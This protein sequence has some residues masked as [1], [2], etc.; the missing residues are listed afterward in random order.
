MGGGNKSDYIVLSMIMRKETDS[1]IYIYISKLNR[2]F[3][4]RAESKCSSNSV[5]DEKTQCS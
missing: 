4:K 1:N 2:M 3:L 5:D